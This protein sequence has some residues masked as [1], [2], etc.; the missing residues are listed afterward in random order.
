[1]EREALY[2]QLGQLISEMPELGGSAPIPNDTL[3]WLGRAHLLV[4]QAGVA[5]GVDGVPVNAASDC[6]SGVLRENDANAIK[7]AVFRALSHAEPQLPAA[8]RGGF[9]AVNARV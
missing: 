8:A 4:Q 6:L 1:M 5:N 7:A 3:R 2:L 9:V